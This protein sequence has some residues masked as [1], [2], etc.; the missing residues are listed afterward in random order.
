LMAQ[1]S[2]DQL[3]QVRQLI[4]KGLAPFRRGHRLTLPITVRMV[5]ARK[6]L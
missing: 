2:A 3:Q 4:F 6:P 5:A 1:L